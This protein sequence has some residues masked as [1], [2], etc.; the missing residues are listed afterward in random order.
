MPFPPNFADIW[1]I[2]QPPDTE[3]ANL[4]GQNIRGLKNDIMQR[5]SLLSGTIANRPTPEVN[6]A[7]AN[8]G[9]IGY[10]IIYISTDTNQ[11][12]QWSGIAWVDI[13][14][15]VG[16]DVIASVNLPNQA[17]QIASTVL[18]PVPINKA[19][20]YR[21]SIDTLITTAGTSGTLSPEII[22]NN[23]ITTLVQGSP[24]LSVTG[25]GLESTGEFCFYSA[26]SQNISF[27][28]LFAGTAGAL[29]YTFRIRLEFLG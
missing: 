3:L 9:G 15:S 5:M 26:Q 22:S 28:V 11:I 24:A 27:Q 18:Y 7:T 20:M 2:S 14:A 10:G 29:Q 4:L 17:G 8:W 12:F 23:G 19:G 6:S 25:A 16:S 13:T 21:A 1:D